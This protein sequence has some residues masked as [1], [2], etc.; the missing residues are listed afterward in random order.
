M[1]HG[2]FQGFTL[3]FHFS[4]N[5]YFT[6]RVLKKSYVMTS[7]PDPDMPLDYDGPVLKSAK[8]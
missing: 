8:A 7:S 6:D 2:Q 3:S 1:A 5:P 4:E